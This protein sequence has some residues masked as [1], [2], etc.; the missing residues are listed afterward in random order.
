MNLPRK[1]K[2]TFVFIVLLFI[3]GYSLYQYAYK[4]HKTIDEK[5]V[6]FSGHSE[7]FLEKVKE[8][9]NEWQDV[10]VELE[11]TITSKD[12]RGITLISSIYCKLEKEETLSTLQVGENISIKG[13]VIG[14]DD[15]LEEVKLDQTI[16]K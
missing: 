11:G 12:E 7:V 2:V 15:L 1:Y 3:G 4:P 5:T 14:Y 8:G 6:M 10:V 9:V 13:R 16:I